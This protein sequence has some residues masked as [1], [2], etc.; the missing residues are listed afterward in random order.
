[1]PRQKKQRLKRRPDGYYVCR[2]KDQ[3]FYSMDEDDALAQREEYRRLEKAGELEQLAG[4]KL[5]QFA[6]RWI[7]SAKTGTAAHTRNEAKIQLRKLTDALGHLYLA[8]IKPSDIRDVYGSAFAGLS[9]SYI[10]RSAQLY[11]ALFDAAVDDGYIKRNP[12]RQ[13]SAKP[14]RGTSG[15][16]RAIT[17]QERVW[18]ETLCTDHRAH[19]AVMAM[20]YAGIR[21]QEMKAL[22]IDRSVDFKTGEIHLKDFAHMDGYNQYVITKK[23]KTDKAIR[24]IPLFTPLRNTLE[25]RH[26]LLI[27]SASGDQ[28]TVTA[29]KSVYASYVTAMETAI[30]GVSRRWYGRTKEHQAIIA[31]GGQLPPWVPFTVV[32]YDLRYSFCTMCRDNGVELKTCVRWMGHADAKMILKIYDDAPDSRSKTEAEKLEKKL[33]RSGNGSGAKNETPETI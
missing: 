18:I 28:V 6:D 3:W 5:Q 16:H 8:D 7:K 33:F 32:P 25:G 22:N 19:P 15:G 1:M 31:E 9:D 23:G 13:D 24:T 20:L 11:K 10:R 17:P 30:N 14:H 12:A 26:G 21:P 29:W 4:P 27:T 2:Y